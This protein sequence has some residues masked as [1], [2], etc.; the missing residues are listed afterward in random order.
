MCYSSAAVSRF[1]SLM[2]VLARHLLILFCIC[3]LNAG[4]A[5]SREDPPLPATELVIAALGDIMMP[6]SIQ[7]AVARS[8][9][10]YDLLFE[11]IAP[12]LVSADIAFANLE[13]TVDHVSAA[14]GYPRFNAR[15]ELLAALKKAGIG[16]VSLANNHAMDAGMNGLKRTL[17]N[18]RAAGL[19]FVGAG[20]TRAETEGPTYMDVRGVRVAFFAYTYG[21]NKGMTKKKRDGPGVNMLRPDA[22]DEL[23]RAATAVRKARL[24]ADLVVVSLH[25]SDEY[26][27]IPTLWQRRAAAE[28]VEAGAD[29][30]LGHHPHVLQPIESFIAR[31][32]RQGLIAFSLGNF[33]SS[34]N[35]EIS[36][37]NRTHAKALRGD[38]IILN[39]YAK[40][41]NGKTAVLRAEFVPLWTLRDRIGKTVMF[42]PVNIARET[43]RIEGRTNRAR[44]DEDALKLLNYRKKIITELLTV[45]PAP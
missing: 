39:I 17:D 18:L 32:G 43:A 22:E 4:A 3:F 6:V 35:S 13:T 28:L 29:V 19:L 45:G 42:R 24:S 27:T 8:R 5:P 9:D 36:N 7:S 34:Q 30:I 14:S 44:E 1:L 37:K 38:G 21:T 41:E 33:I 16:I 11:K 15:P 12:D 2:R 31:N 20:K 26:C 10:Q 40:K 23:A 25:W